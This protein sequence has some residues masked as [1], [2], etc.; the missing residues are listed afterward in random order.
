MR[1]AD[2]KIQN[3]SGG[4]S[5]VE[6]A[7]VLLVV[8]LM[9]MGAVS[10]LQ[11]QR[12]RVRYTDSSAALAQTKQ[13][14]LSF[15][16]VNGFLPCPDTDGDGVENRASGVCSS[17]F[18]QV[19]FR[20]IGLRGADVRDGFGVAIHYA[21]NAG[22]T[23]LSAMRDA[24]HAASYFCNAACQASV[25]LPVFRL[26]TPPTATQAGVGNYD[27]CAV[28]NSCDAASD[29]EAVSLP[30]VLVAWNQRGQLLCAAR[31][32]AERENCDEDG[33]F[34]Q[35]GFAPLEAQAGLFDDEVAGVS[36]YD[37]KAH[38]LNSH[39]DALRTR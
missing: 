4:F 27:V 38:Y 17:A 13:A 2:D 23:D 5:L 8:G 6:L 18:G 35:G 3:G 31:P 10:M 26:T 7:L 28:G 21:V 16:V 19:P 39:P 15:V 12:E 9:M 36:A 34:W 22:V 33:F 24:H 32:E 1:N 20:T 25:D 30:V 37:I 14:L 11:E 29:K